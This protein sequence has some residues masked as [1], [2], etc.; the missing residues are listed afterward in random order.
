MRSKQPQRSMHV[1]PYGLAVR[2][3]ADDGHG[4]NVLPQSEGVGHPRRRLPHPV[5]AHKRLQVPPP[6]AIVL[7]AAGGNARRPVEDV[8]LALRA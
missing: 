3:V 8:R 6:A 1:R 4:V 7:A 2:A 5:D